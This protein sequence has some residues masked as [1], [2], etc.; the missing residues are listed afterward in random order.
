VWTHFVGSRLTGC[1]D[2][3]HLR[4]SFA[5]LIVL[6]AAYILAHTLLAAPLAWRTARSGPP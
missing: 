6:V 2:K 3:R 5:A 1:I 4:R